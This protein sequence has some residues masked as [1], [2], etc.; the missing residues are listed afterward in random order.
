[1]NDVKHFNVIFKALES[2]KSHPVEKQAYRNESVRDILYNFPWHL[3]K[4]SDGM[5]DLYMGPHHLSKRDPSADP[6][7]VSLSVTANMD[8][9]RQRL[10]WSLQNNHRQVC[11]NRV[12][13]G[14][15]SFC[16]SRTHGK[17]AL[18]YDQNNVFLFKTNVVFKNNNF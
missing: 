15:F 3:G 7:G 2:I 8:T 10:L 13:A 4:R 5:T 11:I 12:M 14:F 1:M 18:L 6:G 17:H 16:I 9:L